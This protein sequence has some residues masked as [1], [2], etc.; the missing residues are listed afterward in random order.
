MEYVIG[1]LITLFTIFFVNRFIKKEIDSQSAISISY[2]QSHIHNLIDP[3]LPDNSTLT[4]L[5]PTQASKYLEETQQKFIIV[6][7][8]AYWIKDNEFF[9]AN[10]I[11]GS[12]DRE[13][14][15]LVDT[16]SMSKVELEKIIFIVEKLT[17]ETE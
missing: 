6:E 17:G 9:V 14:A 7:E 16:M 10:M 12:I 1:S 2:S 13:S 5:K 8:K 4:L 11:D 15:Q 3:F